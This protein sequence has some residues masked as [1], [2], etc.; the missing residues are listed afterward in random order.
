MPIK[1]S[2]T[3]RKSLLRSDWDL[4]IV[5][6][7]HKM[8]A[9]SLDRT[10]YA[11]RLGQELSK[12]MDH[13]LL[14]TAT[15]HKGDPEHFRRF[16]ALLD[17]DVYGAIESLQQAMKEQEA[18]FYLRR[19]KEALVTFPN[20]GDGEV[21]KLFTNRE[22]RSAAFDL[23]GEELDFYDELSRFVE[24]RFIELKGRAG[25][26]MVALG[27]NEYDTAY[28]LGRDYWLYAV[29]DRGGTPELHTIQDPA[30]LSWQ[31]VMTV[32]PYQLSPQG[33]L[34]ADTNRD[35]G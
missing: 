13:F 31:P 18:R 24:V 25:V 26:G 2:R 30:R 21:R 34:Q 19:T 4:V 22:V 7:A 15:P 28:R 35:D 23:D 29:F 32:E 27:R 5:D 1:A 11:Y 17:T 10:T 16:L 8:I 3:P 20:P 33:I 6:E 9:R 12:R 14:M